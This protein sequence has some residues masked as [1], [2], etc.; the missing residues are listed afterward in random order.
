MIKII[1]III[2]ISLCPQKDLNGEQRTLACLLNHHH[3]LVSSSL[4]FAADICYYPE[5]FEPFVTTLC[6]LCDLT[7]TSH[8]PMIIIACK[9]R[10]MSKELAFYSLL[11]SHFHLNPIDW[12][13]FW[14]HYRKLGFILLSLERR[15]QPLPGGCSDDFESLLLSWMTLDDD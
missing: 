7:T 3:H 13:R 6:D 1:I 10:E 11:G 2:I 9:I 14:T 5:L 8:P 12:N 4:I 15:D